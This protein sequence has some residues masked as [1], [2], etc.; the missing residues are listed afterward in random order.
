MTLF[1]IQ[2]NQGLETGVCLETGD[3][4]MMTVAMWIFF[5]SLRC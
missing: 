3:V 5:M 1:Q 2:R 4:Y